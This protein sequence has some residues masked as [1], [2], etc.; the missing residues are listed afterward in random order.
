MNCIISYYFISAR[1]PQGREPIKRNDAGYIQKW[2]DSVVKHGL[3]P[4]LFH[5]GLSS[6]FLNHFPLIKF[7]QVPPVPNRMQLHD[8]HWVVSYNYLKRH[9]EIENVFFTDCPDC[10]VINNPF[11]QLIYDSDTLYCG[12]ESESISQSEWMQYAA[13]NPE[14]LKLEWF[15]NILSSND[16]LYNGGV[17]GGGRDIVLEF[18]ELISELVELV[19]FRPNDGTGDMALY[20]YILHRYFNPVHGFPINSIF[21]AYEDRTDVWFKHK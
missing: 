14:L 2:Y 16:P 10:E 20:N 15:S 13:N 17:L 7:V 6:E 18:T 3:T 9:V 12:D 8:Y 4:I 21:K 19:K 5:D 1:D 11:T